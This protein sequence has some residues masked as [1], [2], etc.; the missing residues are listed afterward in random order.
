MPE[1]FTSPMDQYKDIVILWSLRILLD[2]KGYTLMDISFGL[3]GNER[4]LAAVGLEHLLDK[5]DEDNEL[6]RTEVASDI[7]RF[8]DRDLP[9]K[10][11][12]IPADKPGQKTLIKIIS[13]EFNIKL[14]EGFFSQQNMKRVH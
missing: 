10:I 6:I 12:I 8:G 14:E 11:E 13:S 2:L 1:D 9:S 5:Y 3:Y 4:A 7:K